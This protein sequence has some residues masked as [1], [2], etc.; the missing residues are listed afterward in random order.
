MIVG[1]AQVEFQG[2]TNISAARW[3][4]R[5][6]PEHFLFFLAVSVVLRLLG[7]IQV[8]IVSETSNLYH[9]S[10]E[11]CS[12]PISSFPNPGPTLQG[13]SARVSERR[14]PSLVEVNKGFL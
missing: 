11:L 8:F 13:A 1:L 2:V 6:Y 3:H 9:F 4:R 10:A 12:R 14:L 5:T 7:F